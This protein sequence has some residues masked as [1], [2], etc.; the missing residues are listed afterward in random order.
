[1]KHQEEVSTLTTTMSPGYLLL[2][3]NRVNH[4]ER[5][6]RAVSHGGSY[7]NGSVV[8]FEFSEAASDFSAVKRWCGHRFPSVSKNDATPRRLIKL[9]E[10]LSNLLFTFAVRFQAQ[11]RLELLLTGFFLA[12]C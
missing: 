11:R 1:M 10:C 5:K 4:K 8:A 6:Y 9:R 12:R 3:I 7:L 2:L